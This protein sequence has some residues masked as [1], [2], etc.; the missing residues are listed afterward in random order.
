V[1]VDLGFFSMGR[2]STM[3]A[4]WVH[5]RTALRALGKLH[6]RLS[7][8]SANAQFLR[9]QEHLLRRFAAYLV[10]CE[11]HIRLCGIGARIVVALNY[12]SM[13]VQSSTGMR[14]RGEIG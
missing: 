7:V 8:L 12:A 13:H 2:V 14:S 4:A 6:T 3:G 11:I 5:C 1:K 10:P 9:T